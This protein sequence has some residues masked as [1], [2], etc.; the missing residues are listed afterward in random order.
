[1]NEVVT[2]NQGRPRPSYFY[3]IQPVPGLE[4]FVNQEV[5]CV[6]PKTKQEIFGTVTEFFW[7]FDWEEPPRGFLMGIFG[8]EP[9]LLREVLL[10]TDPGY[11]DSWARL[12]LI[13]EK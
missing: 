5:R 7:T 1:M 12:I 6:H 8:V 13:K 11:K 4:F 2:I 3:I 9:V 10:A